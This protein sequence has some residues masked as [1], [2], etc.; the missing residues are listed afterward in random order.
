L[1]IEANASM[2][3]GVRKNAKKENFCICANPYNNAACIDGNSSPSC[4]NGNRN[5]FTAKH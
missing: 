1:V 3:L 2:Y 4:N 5:V